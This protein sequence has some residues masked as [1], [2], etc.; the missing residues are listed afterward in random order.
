MTEYKNIYHQFLNKIDGDKTAAKLQRIQTA[1]AQVVKFLKDIIESKY[2]RIVTPCNINVKLDHQD[3][4][5]ELATRLNVKGIKCTPKY[6]PPYYSSS[7]YD[8]SE[9]E[10]YEI[11]IHTS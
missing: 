5:N 4:L 1:E 8:D 10:Y 7:R 6:H 2:T 11:I 3:E 9:P